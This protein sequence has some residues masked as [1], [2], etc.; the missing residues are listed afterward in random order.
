M[1][2]RLHHTK[3]ELLHFFQQSPAS[4]LYLMGDLDDKFWSKTRWFSLWDKDGMKAVVLLYTGS[5]PSTVLAFYHEGPGY[6][7]EL[8][9]RITALL[10]ATV[11]AHLQEGVRELV[12]QFEVLEKHGLHYR[13][14]LK[15]TPPIV[16]DG[17]IKRLDLS[18]LLKAEN[19]YSRA[20]EGNWFEPYSLQ[21]GYYLGYF[22]GDDLIGIA[23]THI[24]S[25]EYGIAALGNITTLPEHRGKRISSKL[26]QELCRQLLL[27]VKDI[28]LN[29][30]SDNA[31][32]IKV[33]KNAGFEI[34]GAYEECLVRNKFAAL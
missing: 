17:N 26:T 27:H 31:S 8:L 6:V 19:L 5:N 30:E 15:H 9:Q 21:V 33:Y 20:Y 14:M 13:M 12:P 7:A 23:G 4:Y 2:I 28:G 10:P 1:T 24:F 18:Q 11:Y 25:E 32:A 34:T 16:N 3:E 22:D 29:V